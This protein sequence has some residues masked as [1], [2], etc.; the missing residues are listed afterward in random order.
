MLFR[1]DHSWQTFLMAL[2][3]AGSAAAPA[4]AAIVDLE[5]D[6]YRVFCGYLD[7]LDNPKVKDLSPKKRD[8]K[9]AKMAKLK[10]KDLLGHVDKARQYGDTC[11]EVGKRGRAA[12][13]GCSRDQRSYN[14]RYKLAFQSY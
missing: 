2:F 9:I 4:S 5:P 13:E 10:V 3:F 8:R 1:T 12:I 11:E 14:F 6:D 7:A